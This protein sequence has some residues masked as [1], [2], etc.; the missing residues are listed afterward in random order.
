MGKV[1]SE[2]TLEEIH[3][4]TAIVMSNNVEIQVSHLY[5]P[6]SR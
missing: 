6:M 2:G 1:K 4:H 5:M 3:K